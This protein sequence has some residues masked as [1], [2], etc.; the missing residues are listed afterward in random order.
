[1]KIICAVRD[2]A[3]DSFG[4]PFF[5]RARGEALRGFMD[6]INNKDSALHAHPEDY[7]L[8][9]IGAFDDLSGEIIPEKPT[10]IQIGKD[11]VQS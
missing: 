4:Q 1:M 7:D 3:V 11:A 10:M 8:Y 9:V 2:R 5:V 6:E